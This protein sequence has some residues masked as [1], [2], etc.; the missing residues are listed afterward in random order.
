M[1]RIVDFRKAILAGALGAVGWDAAVRILAASGVPVFDLVRELGTLAFT[2][3][4]PMGWWP[5]GMAAHALVGAG[6]A[7]FYAD[8]FWGR[9]RWPPALQGLAFA[10]LP[11]LLAILIVIPQLELMHAN[12]T[13]VRLDWRWYLAGLDETRL[14]G[15]LIGHAVFGLAVGTIYTHPVGYRDGSAEA[16]HG[17][18]RQ[19]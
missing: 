2:D 15:L 3:G 19:R 12:A 7:L 17:A 13:A 11:A 6:W 9:L 4:Q 10:A 5:V 16:A 18:E 1:L 14:G 8:F